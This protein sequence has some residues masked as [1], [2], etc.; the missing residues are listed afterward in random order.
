MS[1]TAVYTGFWLDHGQSWLLKPT[2]TLNYR[3]AT[4]L[5]AALSATVALAA[6]P[7]WK[8]WRLLF[9]TGFTRWARNATHGRKTQR[10]AQVILRNS[11]TAAGAFLALSQLAWNRRELSR[12]SHAAR[13]GPRWKVIAL[14]L[15]AL[16]H[17]II[18]IAASVLVSQVETGQTV[19]SKVTAT[20]GAWRP[21]IFPNSTSLELAMAQE[22][23]LN[24]SIEADNYARN[25]YDLAA[26]RAI[27]DCGKLQTRRLSVHANKTECPFLPGGCLN[28]TSNALSLDSGNISF[29][30]LGINIKHARSLFIRR[31]TTCAPMPDQPF[32]N[33]VFSNL[34]PGFEAFTRKERLY[35]YSL[36]SN[37][38]GVSD[39]YLFRNHNFSAGYELHASVFPNDPVYEWKHPLHSTKNDSDTTLILLRGAGIAFGNVADDPWFSAHRPPDGFVGGVDP[40]SLNITSGPYYMDRIVNFLGCYEQAQTCSSITDQCTSWTGLFS[41]RVE[42]SVTGVSALDHSS[43]HIAETIRAIVTVQGAAVETSLADSIQDRPAG[44]VLQATRLM[45]GSWQNSLDDAQWEI[46]LRAWFTF[47]MAR[48]Q[49][50]VLN[51]IEKPAY[52]NEE[53]A[54]N[55]WERFNLTSLCGTIMFRSPDHTSLSTVGILVIFV[56][57]LVL[58]VLSL[59]D[60]AAGLMP[61][62]KAKP[63]IVA[64]EEDEVLAL[65]D[66]LHQSEQSME[67]SEPPS[68]AGAIERQHL[69]ARNERHPD[70]E[71]I[72]G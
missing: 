61:S 18:F 38:D 57:A 32:L 65:L 67:V 68:A 29:H 39:V 69:M 41:Q 10:E 11:E 42:P 9:H 58:A 53:F 70:V 43:K 48:L 30:D 60:T 21:A 1:S 15:A 25:C 2:L 3:D 45:S 27:L 44:A 49:L 7:S 34:D 52:V 46:E 51:S 26:P 13:Y 8:F 17:C 54:V 50:N 63:A 66:R 55:I 33:H 16:C 22:L 72:E 59:S 20:C 36:L 62:W 14:I 47:A 56:V 40:Q 64:W 31:R 24:S 37:S 5:I 12:S 23:W 4:V 19:V 35:N 71:V 28:G 6:G